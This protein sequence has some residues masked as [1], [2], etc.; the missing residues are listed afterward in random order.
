LA[1][2]VIDSEFRERRFGVFEGLTRDQCAEHYPSAWRDWVAQTSHPPGAE[3]RDDATARI[4]RALLRVVGDDTALV[5]SHGGVMRLWLMQLLGKSVP[6]IG[7]ADI[8]ELDHDGDVFRA[9]LRA[10]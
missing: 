1:P 9:K 8:L 3:P 4:Q 7:N 10:P 5:V 2:P 6:L